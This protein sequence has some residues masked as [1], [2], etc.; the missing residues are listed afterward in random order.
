[1]FNILVSSSMP[2]GGKRRGWEVLI[3]ALGIN[4]YFAV[5]FLFVLAFS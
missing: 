5:S 3:T 2:A 4:T 1:M